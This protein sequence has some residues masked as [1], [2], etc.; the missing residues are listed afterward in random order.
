MKKRTTYKDV[1]NDLIKQL[2]NDREMMAD[3][4]CFSD[5]EAELE[6]GLEEDKKLLMQQKWEK[7]V[8]RRVYDALNVLYAA[9]VLEKQG[10]DVFCNADSIFTKMLQKEACEGRVF[11]EQKSKRQ[12]KLELK[13]EIEEARRRV[14]M[15]KQKLGK[16]E[17]HFH[18][19]KALI[20]RNRKTQH[21]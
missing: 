7:N 1:A 19:L 13:Q 16:D 17:A 5:S 20:E 18:G 6:A 2:T 12:S 15:K 11:Q 3:F 9:G 8:R 14:E 4:G 10:K 21:H